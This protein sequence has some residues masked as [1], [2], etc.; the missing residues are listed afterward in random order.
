MD[1]L[2]LLVKFFKFYFKV[3][4]VFFSFFFF[5][6]AVQWNQERTTT[7]QRIT[8]RTR[9]APDAT[10]LLLSRFYSWVSFD[11]LPLAGSLSVYHTGRPSVPAIW[12]HSPALSRIPL[13]FAG[14]KD[15]LSWQMLPCKP[16]VSWGCGKIPGKKTQVTAYSL[17]KITLPQQEF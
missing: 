11:L 15:S 2:R 3:V 1:V 12:P 4:L 5:T 17:R 7:S 10:F 6:V 9:A 13:S 16:Y 8:G 14:Q